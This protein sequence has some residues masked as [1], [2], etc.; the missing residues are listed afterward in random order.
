MHKLAIFAE[1]YTEVLLVQRLL[2]EIADKDN[3]VIKQIKIR[4]GRNIKRS[5]T[6]IVAAKPATNQNFHVLL[7]DCEGE[8]QVKTRI[9][10]EHQNLTNSG[11][12]KILGIRDVSPN[13]SLGDIPNLMRG[14]KYKIKTALTPVE[15]VLATME[16]EAWFLAEH[17]H[18]KKINPLIT[19][20]SVITNLGFNPNTEDMTI[21]PNPANDLNNVYALAAKAY[22]KGHGQTVDVLDIPDMYI[23]LKNKI[24]SLKLLTDNIDE[25]LNLAT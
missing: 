22:I 24:A 1:G 15:F 18:Y 10:E 8:N 16:V 2:E 12:Y 4:G 6:T 23:N 19:V 9:L 13:F 25:F 11:Y 5:V 21:R 14:L 7:I 3:I 20:G 17:T